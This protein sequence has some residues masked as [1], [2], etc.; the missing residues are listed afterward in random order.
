MWFATLERDEKLSRVIVCKDPLDLEE[1]VFHGNIWTFNWP[2]PNI[3][4]FIVQLVE[5]RTSVTG[6]NPVKVLIFFQVSYTIV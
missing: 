5:H 2:A 6:S 4:G 3:S 1:E